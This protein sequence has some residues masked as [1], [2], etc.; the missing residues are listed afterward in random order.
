ME[1][2]FSTEVI[3]HCLRNVQKRRDND[4]LNGSGVESLAKALHYV[5]AA[6]KNF[7][8]ESIESERQRLIKIPYE[9][10]F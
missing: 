8:L 1:F 5:C 2:P 6:W 10:V 3:I 9:V 4:G 7:K